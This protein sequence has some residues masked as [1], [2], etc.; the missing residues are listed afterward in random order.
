M[1]K[2]EQ[3]DPTRQLEEKRET[4]RET[5]LSR[6]DTLESDL[7]GLE[8]R[9]FAEAREVK[10][11]KTL[12]TIEGNELVADTYRDTRSKIIGELEEDE[13][14][15]RREKGL[16]KVIDSL[17][18]LEQRCIKDNLDIGWAA[19]FKKEEGEWDEGA[20]SDWVFDVY[21]FQREFFDQQEKKAV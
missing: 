2:S 19:S 13:A 10:I 6:F 4:K 14:R 18:A 5:P 20:V 21:S 3:F 8:I 15:Q 12:T 9:D 11:L 17:T 16:K 7:R 1:P